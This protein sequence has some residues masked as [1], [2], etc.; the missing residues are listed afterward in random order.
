MEILEDFRAGATHTGFA[1]VGDRALWDPV[2][3]IARGVCVERTGRAIVLRG[4]GD[5][6]V[7]LVSYVAPPRAKDGIVTALDHDSRGHGKAVLALR[8]GD[9]VEFPAYR[10]RGPSTFRRWGGGEWDEE[11]CGRD[12]AVALGWIEE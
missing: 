1:L 9:V 6:D 7:V 12:V 3:R 4:G 5:L 2:H 10:G 11:V 8:P